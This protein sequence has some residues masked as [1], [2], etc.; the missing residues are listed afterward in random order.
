MPVSF[1][2]EENYLK[3]LE[4]FV[5]KRW[6]WHLPHVHRS[7]MSPVYYLECPSGA[8]PLTIRKI[9]KWK[10]L[11]SFGAAGPLCLDPQN[12]DAF[13][14]QLRVFAKKNQVD[15]IQVQLTPQFIDD[16][17]SLQKS[18]FEHGFEPFPL[19]TTVVDLTSDF[20]PKLRKSFRNEW[21]KSASVSVHSN[22]DQGLLTEL[23]DVTKENYERTGAE[24]EPFSVFETY[25]DLVNSGGAFLFRY[26]TILGKA[27]ALIN[28][29]DRCAYYGI[30]AAQTA[31]LKDQPNQKIQ[32]AVLKFLSEKKFHFYD[33]GLIPV[34]SWRNKISEKEQG[35]AHFKL[36]L[37]GDLYDV[38]V[39]ELG[40]NPLYRLGLWTKKLLK[41]PV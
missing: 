18:L 11:C 41:K 26:E 36:G 17:A 31:I 1:L 15:R 7:A 40:I 2:S 30:G 37:G 8:W 3:L 34:S 38:P 14:R 20:K 19:K 32:A 28:V 39:W 10:T 16:Q 35:I 27:F 29:I 25:R 33:V 6:I 5:G 13:V 12:A 4:K 9:G 22:L 21:N 23:Y 24:L